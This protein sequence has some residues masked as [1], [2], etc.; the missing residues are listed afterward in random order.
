MYF[1]VDAHNNITAFGGN[2]TATVYSEY[3]S[4][5][6]LRFRKS[7][8]DPLSV[9]FLS[10]IL[11]L[12]KYG[13]PKCDEPLIDFFREFQD[14]SEL[15]EATLEGFLENG[16]IP[17]QLPMVITRTSYNSDDNY[18]RL[19]IYNSNGKLTFVSNT[20]DNTYS[21]IDSQQALQVLGEYGIQMN[22]PSSDLKEIVSAQNYS[23]INEVIEIIKNNI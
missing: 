7:C 19:L 23:G 12:S 13:M 10:K 15:A 2:T 4:D 14:N 6:S 8:S 22:L 18:P 20:H 11:D 1:V 21:I 3:L 16:S 9:T 17:F 5:G